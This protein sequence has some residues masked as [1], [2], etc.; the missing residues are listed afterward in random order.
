MIDGQHLNR[1]G[2]ANSH[3]DQF[4]SSENKTC[5]GKATSKTPNTPGTYST[6]YTNIGQVIVSSHRKLETIANVN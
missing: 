1:D 3:N 4:L 2:I 5:I 6:I